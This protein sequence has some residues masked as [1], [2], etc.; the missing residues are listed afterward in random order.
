MSCAKNR[1]TLRIGF[2]RLNAFA[3]R[4]GAML[5]FAMQGGMFGRSGIAG[6]RVNRLVAAK[7]F[8]NIKKKGVYETVHLPNVLVPLAKGWC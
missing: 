5:E 2:A 1:K 8:G 6:C 3:Q 4:R 7:M